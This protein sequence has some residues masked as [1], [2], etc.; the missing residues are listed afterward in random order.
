[1]QKRRRLAEDAR[2]VA[3]AVGE[4]WAESLAV[5]RLGLLALQ[6]GDHAMAKV[7]LERGLNMCRQ[8][9]DPYYVWQALEGLGRV[10]MAEGRARGSVCAP[11]RKPRN[12]L[13]KSG[14]VRGLPTRWRVFAALAAR[15]SKPELALQLAGAAAAL[16][17]AIGVPQSPMRRDLL[18]RW[19]PALQLSSR[20]KMSVL[21]AGRLGKP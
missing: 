10:A 14:I 11:R 5:V 2:N 17:E 21:A 12:S 20:S 16:R 6:R 13:T 8:Q 18:E 3:H 15:L 7:D 1:M 9:R 19:L 4:E